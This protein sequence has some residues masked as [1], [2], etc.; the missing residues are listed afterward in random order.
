MKTVI[1]YN[2]TSLIIIL[3]LFILLRF[4]GK[5]DLSRDKRMII[6]VIDII[7]VVCVIAFVLFIDAVVVGFIGLVPN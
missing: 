7:L 6:K 3:G 5:S 4:V 2:I 1:L